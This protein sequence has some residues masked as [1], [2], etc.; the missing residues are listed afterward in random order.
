MYK[1]TQFRSAIALLK[2]TDEQNS[3]GLKRLARTEFCLA[4]ALQQASNEAEG[5]EVKSA[6]IGHLQESVALSSESLPESFNFETLEGVEL[7]F[8]FVDR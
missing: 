1:S 5:H 8:P 6:A 4:R 3:P 7:L 2:R